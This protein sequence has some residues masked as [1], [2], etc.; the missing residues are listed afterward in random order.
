MVFDIADS[1]K[2]GVLSRHEFDTAFGGIAFHRGSNAATFEAQTIKRIGACHT[3]EG[4]E[5]MTRRHRGLSVV[6]AIQE[7]WRQRRQLRRE[8]PRD[9]V[10]KNQPPQFVHSW[11]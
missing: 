4:H 5:R 11:N 10:E 7:N 2:N 8:N 6:R 1:S 9:R 3:A